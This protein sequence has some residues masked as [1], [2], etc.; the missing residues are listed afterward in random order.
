ME[1]GVFLPIAKGGFIIS[2]NVPPTWP[3]WE[4]NK[5]VTLKCESLGFD[6]ALSMVKFRGF[7]GAT[8]YWDHA[9]DS[10][11]LTADIP[12]LTKKEVNVNVSDGIVSIS[13]ERKFENEKESDNYHYR[14]RQYGSFLRTFN[15]PE[16]VKEEEIT[17]NFKNGTLSIELPK[18]EVVLPK[19]RQI[20]IN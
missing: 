6:F 8:E 16:T 18:Q 15:L 2:K 19:E 11:T 9:L 10:F 20:K 13:G 3:T 5:N 4:L 12:G 17:A 7:G 1:I 14:E